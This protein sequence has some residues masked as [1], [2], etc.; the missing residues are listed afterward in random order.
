MVL[1]LAQEVVV[2]ATMLIVMHCCG[3]DGCPVLQLTHG[4]TLENPTVTQQHVSH[5]HYSRYMDAVVVGVGRFVACLHPLQV[6][7]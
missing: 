2:Q 5:L 4:S 7:A 1:R 6:A 3:P